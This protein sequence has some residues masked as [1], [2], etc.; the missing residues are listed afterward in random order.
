VPI[1][2]YDPNEKVGSLG[3]GAGHYVTGVDPL[4]YVVLFEN[5]ATA[6]APAQEVVITDQLDATTLDLSTF[7]L[8]PMTFGERTVVP[9]PG[10]QEFTAAVDLRPAQNLLCDIDTRLDSVTGLLTWRLTSID[11][12]T[13]DLPE[14]PNL[15]CLPPNATPPAGEGGIV[16]TVKAKAGLATD[17]QIRN[18][19]RIVFDVNPPIDTPMWL[20]TIDNSTPQSQVTAVSQ[21][22]CSQAL[23]VQ[24]SGTDV[25]AGIQSYDV[26]V[27]EDG[28]PFTLW[29]ND[30]T[31]TTGTFV[32]RW[33]R[34]YAFHSVAR[35][36]TGNEEG[37]PAVADRQVTVADC[38]SHDLAVTK[39]TVPGTVTLTDNNPRRKT[40]VKVEIQNRGPKA[41]TIGSLEDLRALVALEV[42]SL[43]AGPCAA[44]TPVLIAGKPQKKRPITLKSKQKLSVV[45]RVT[46]TCANDAAQGAGHEDFRLSARVQQ[47]ALGGSD[48]HPADDVCPRN[49]PPPYEIDPNPDGTIKDK[50][51][52]EPKAD[53][54]LGDPVLVDVVV[55]R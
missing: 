43:G 14:D 3:A 15:G 28:G 33:G 5:V 39:I 47:S 24:W 4:R 52:G 32:G 23:Q 42:E 17:T 55:K 54:T 8:G 13:G 7:S 38:G 50:G 29:L 40:L 26:F 22:P 21:T 31:S 45:F 19:A 6:T 27:S 10:L 51:C 37:A 2:P 1:G 46:F 25:G 34:S 20:N 30:T 16:F 35:D 12:A 41:E 49:V 44:P 11:P 9:P 48:G 18:Q 53:K 36:Q